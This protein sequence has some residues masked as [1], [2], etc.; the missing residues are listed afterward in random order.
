MILLVTVVDDF[1]T[2]YS[3]DLGKFCNIVAGRNPAPSK[4][5][6]RGL[7]RTDRHGENE[8]KGKTIK[9]EFEEIQEQ[10]ECRSVN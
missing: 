4:L 1:R 5:T 6:P 10:H 8:K 9:L 3:S 7:R 2:K